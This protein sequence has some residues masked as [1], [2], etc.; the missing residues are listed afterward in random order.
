MALAGGDGE[1]GNG[2]QIL[3]PHRHA[4]AERQQMRTGNRC[5]HPAG[6]AAD[7]GHGDA[8]VEAQD[9]LGMASAT[10]PAWPMTRRTMLLSGRP[11][12]M[13]STTET[14]SFWVSKRVS[15]TRLPSR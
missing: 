11:M 3:A 7:P 14:I 10:R 2:A 4:A 5:Q 6:P 15:S 9:Q 13:K 8:V 12:G 1:I